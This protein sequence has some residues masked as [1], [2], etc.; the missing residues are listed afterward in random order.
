MN[1]PYDIERFKE[2]AVHDLEED[3]I[4]NVENVPPCGQCDCEDEPDYYYDF[5]KAEWVITCPGCGREVRG[6]TDRIVMAR[7]REE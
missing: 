2:D 4:G 3:V 5:A 6:E 1:D 7:W